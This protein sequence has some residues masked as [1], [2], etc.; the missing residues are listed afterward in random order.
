M[1]LTHAL[2]YSRCGHIYCHKVLKP[3]ERGYICSSISGIDCEDENYVAISFSLV[4]RETHCEHCFDQVREGERR[5]VERHL[6]LHMWLF[7]LLLDNRLAYLPFRRLVS[8]LEKTR[9]WTVHAHYVK[10]GLYRPPSWEQCDSRNIPSERQIRENEER[11][12]AGLADA[13]RI[14]VLEYFTEDEGSISPNE[15]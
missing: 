2:L 7:Q 3:C 10:H 5:I 1:C 8:T 14:G 11:I 6:K 13:E 12:R 9:E 15:E 4:S